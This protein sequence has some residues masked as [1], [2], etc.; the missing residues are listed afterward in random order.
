MVCSRIGV[1]YLLLFEDVVQSLFDVCLYDVDSL[2]L[3]E[4]HTDQI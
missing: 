4:P 1:K 2:M 3:T